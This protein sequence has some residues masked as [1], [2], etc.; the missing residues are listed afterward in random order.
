M[1]GPDARRDHPAAAVDDAPA[2]HKAARKAAGSGGMLACQILLGLAILL[3]WQGASGRLV[4][5]QRTMRGSRVAASSPGSTGWAPG[6]GQLGRPQP[7][8]G[9]PVARRSPCRSRPTPGTTRHCH[10]PA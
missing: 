1:T 5:H 10:R 2:D 7:Q 4:H 8:T 3:I 6:T 9:V